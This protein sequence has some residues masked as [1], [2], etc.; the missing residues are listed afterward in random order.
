MTEG[1]K[2]EVTARAMY[3]RWC[4][5]RGHSPMWD[6]LTSSAL[7][8]P[9]M[10]ASAFRASAAWH[11]EKAKKQ[12]AELERWRELAG[13]MREAIEDLPETLGFFGRID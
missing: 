2:I 3:E 9:M 13:G 12:R 8:T 7:Q 4:Q 1:D 10:V 5:E 11:V 6:N